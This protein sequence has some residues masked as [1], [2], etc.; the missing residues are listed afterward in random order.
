MKT[1]R[2]TLISITVSFAFA[3]MAHAQP[4]FFPQ[5][6]A[7]ASKTLTT[8]QQVQETTR[9]LQGL[10]AVSPDPQ[11]PGSYQSAEW[12]LQLVSERFASIDM[13]GADEILRQHLKEQIAAHR[14]MAQA[15]RL[16]RTEFIPALLATVPELRQSVRAQELARKRKFDLTKASVTQDTL[17]FVALLS[18]DKAFVSESRWLSRQTGIITDAAAAFQRSEERLRSAHAAHERIASQLAVK[19]GG[20]FA[21]AQV[22]PVLWAW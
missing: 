1:I 22:V 11:V 3:G 6:D 19:Y 15:F 5:P 9:L 16:A 14:A 12:R 8:W 13:R 20:E 4:A 18:T 2:H 21:K 7:T 10:P 17:D